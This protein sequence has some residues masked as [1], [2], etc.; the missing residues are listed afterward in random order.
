VT[1][2]VDQLLH[3]PGWLVLLVTGLA[4][5]SEDALFVGFVFP[6]ETLA[7]LAGGPPRAAWSASGRRWPS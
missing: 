1:A 6:G 4:V 5:F 7:V 3:A 2:V